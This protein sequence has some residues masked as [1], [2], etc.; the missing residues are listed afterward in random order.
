M[1]VRVKVL[2]KRGEAEVETVAIANSG[3]E[4][5]EPELVVPTKVA[6][7]LGMWPEFSPGTKV[8]AYESPAGTSLFYVVP[9]A[10]NIAV[11]A[12]DKS[13]EPVVTTIAISDKESEVLLSDKLIDSLNI[14]LKKPGMGIW[15]FGDD[16][17]GKERMSEKPEYW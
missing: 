2:I 17:S 10:A 9:K 12:K 14:E 16:P 7:R 15:R 6:E 13:T 4:S 1:A 11:E 8:E 5:D 3:Y